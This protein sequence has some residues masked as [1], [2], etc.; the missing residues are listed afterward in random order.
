M[1]RERVF[2]GEKGGG[3]GVIPARVDGSAILLFRFPIDRTKHWTICAWD[4]Y[5]ISCAIHMRCRNVT[6]VFGDDLGQ[7]M[8]SS[9]WDSLGIVLCVYFNLLLTFQL[10]N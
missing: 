4:N 8:M 1:V 2:G 7:R 5:G 9:V 10:I 3:G 6:L